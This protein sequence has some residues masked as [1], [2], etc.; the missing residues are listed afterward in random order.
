MNKTMVTKKLSSYAI[1]FRLGRPLEVTESLVSLL[2]EIFSYIE[3]KN[4]NN[5]SSI[6][7]I[8]SLILSCQEAEDWLGLADYIEYDLPKALEGVLPD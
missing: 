8:F 6:G 3:G 7:L 1:F 5:G 2:T 4:I